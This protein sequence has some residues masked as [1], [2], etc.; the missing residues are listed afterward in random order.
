MNPNHGAMRE[1]Y[2]QYTKIL[3]EQKNHPQEGIIVMIEDDSNAT[4]W[5]VLFGN[6]PSDTP[7]GKDLARLQNERR[8]DHIKLE[9]QVCS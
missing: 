8:I 6:F 4:K 7:L 2:S 9:I 3:Q 5:T 1:I